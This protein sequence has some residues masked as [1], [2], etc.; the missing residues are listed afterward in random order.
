MPADADLNLLDVARKV[1]LYGIKMHPAKNHDEVNLN[2]SVS[3]TG[4]LV[5]QNM[6][7]INMFS[8]VKIRKLS[9]KRRKFLI[10]LQP[11]RYVRLIYFDKYQKK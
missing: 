6:T 1:E 9:F 3:H 5:F 7:K 11:E 2:L 10:K 8:W 4:I